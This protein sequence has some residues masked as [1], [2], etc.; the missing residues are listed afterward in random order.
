VDAKSKINEDFEVSAVY[1]NNMKKW[2]LA[3][4]GLGMLPILQVISA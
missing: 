4:T 2:F 1:T 3:Q